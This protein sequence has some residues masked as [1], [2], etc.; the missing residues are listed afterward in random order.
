[1]STF[2]LVGKGVDAQPLTLGGGYDDEF[3]P[4]FSQGPSQEIDDYGT[5]VHSQNI[6][7]SVDH[8][9]IRETFEEGLLKLFEARGGELRRNLTAL[10]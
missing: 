2:P 5:I 6:D 7:G 3:V 1:M 10:S 9:K 8:E 4:I